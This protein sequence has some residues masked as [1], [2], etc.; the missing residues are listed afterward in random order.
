MA[1]TRLSIVSITRLKSMVLLPRG[2]EPC[3]TGIPAAEL[4]REANETPLET[5]SLSTPRPCGRIRVQK[6]PAC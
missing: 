2:S 6:L 4:R 3:A 1:Q 5:S